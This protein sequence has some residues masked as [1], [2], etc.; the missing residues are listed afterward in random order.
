MMKKTIVIAVVLVLVMA[1]SPMYA[2]VTY[3]F[4]HIVE[5]GDSPAVL[6]AAANVAQQLFVTVS[7]LG[8]HSGEGRNQVS[9]LF[10]NIGVYS[11]TIADVYFDDAADTLL[12]DIF[13]IID[14]PTPVDAV[15]FEIGASP[16]DLPGGNLLTPPFSRDFA[17]SAQPPPAEKGVDPGE[18]VD[19]IFNLK[20]SMGYSDVIGALNSLTD[21]RIGVH[22]QSLGDDDEW[23]EGYILVPA[24]AA[25]LLG[26]IGIGLVGWLR[27][28]RT[29]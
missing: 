21:L 14:D 15:D 11:S 13:S 25:I 8:Y 22:V 7:D 9:F 19:I 26:G 24:P 4:A 6:S 10:E 23:S 18:W 27:R 5:P 3:S 2:N 12:Q 16:P 1:V 17:V 20:T 29:M 28:R